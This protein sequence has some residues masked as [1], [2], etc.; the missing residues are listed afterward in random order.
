MHFLKFYQ[1]SVSDRT[2]TTPQQ[3]AETNSSQILKSTPNANR[4]KAKCHDYE[5][6]SLCPEGNIS[7]NTKPK[8]GR[9]LHWWLRA[10]ASP[11]LWP[12]AIKFPGTHRKPHKKGKHHK[13]EKASWAFQTKENHTVL[14]FQSST[15]A[16][17]RKGETLAIQRQRGADRF[18]CDNLPANPNTTNK[19]QNTPFTT[20]SSFK[21]FFSHIF[22]SRK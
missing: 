2:V 15:T 3:L 6:S 4:S 14:Q 16:T 8:Q 20:T 10:A 13:L 7:V 21:M 12:H 22:R 17:L 11:F 1:N 5:H 9:G 18:Q 19:N